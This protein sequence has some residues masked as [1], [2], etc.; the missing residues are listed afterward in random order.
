MGDTVYVTARGKV[1]LVG[2]NDILGNY[3]KVA[4]RFGFE[5]LYGH[6]YDHLVTEDD[7]VEIG[8]P[9][10][11]IGSTGRSTGPHLHYGVK[12]YGQ[13]QD[14]YPYCF[15]LLEYLKQKNYIFD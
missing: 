13:D 10:G 14:A 3:V 1:I 4:H 7:L 11:L 15:L 2:Y 12:K 5:T 8:D 9:V 6:L